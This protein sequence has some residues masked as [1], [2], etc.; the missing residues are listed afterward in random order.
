ML[1]LQFSTIFANFRWKNGVF[2]KKQCYVPNFAKSRS[3]LNRNANFFAKCFGEN[4]FKVIKSV[5]G[6]LCKGDLTL[7]V[8]GCDFGWPDYPVGPGRRNFR[9]NPTETFGWRLRRPT[10]RSGQERSRPIGKSICDD[11]E[12]KTMKAGSF[13]LAKKYFCH[14]WNGLALAFWFRRAVRELV[15]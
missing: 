11:E 15:A 14:L 2:L 4:T 8:S 6:L 9:V 7:F 13:L 10:R 12:E 3:I 1:W 5:P